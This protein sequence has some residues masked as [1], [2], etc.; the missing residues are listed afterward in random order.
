MQAAINKHSK[1]DAL[2]YLANWILKMFSVIADL[3]LQ[4]PPQRAGLINFRFG[5]R[6]KAFSAVHEGQRLPLGEV[7]PGG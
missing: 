5:S 4:V 2:I 1:L 3:L 6:S 7:L